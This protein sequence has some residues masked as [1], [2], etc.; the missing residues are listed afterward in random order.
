MQER[1]Q[2][3]HAE[4]GH[5][6]IRLGLYLL[7]PRAL[8]ALASLQP[9]LLSGLLTSFGVSGCTQY[10]LRHSCEGKVLLVEK[11]YLYFEGVVECL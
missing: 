3:L 8:P 9:V 4:L 7:T 1:E 2:A 5:H 6:L 10:F 11:Q